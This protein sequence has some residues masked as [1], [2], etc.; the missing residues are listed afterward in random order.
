[1][2]ILFITPPNYAFKINGRYNFNVNFPL[3]MAYIAAIAEQGGHKV[4]VIDCVAEGW[5]V[6]SKLEDDRVR[7]GISP[8]ELEARVREYSPDIVGISVVTNLA[9]YV[10]KI[11]NAIRQNS[12]A[13]ILNT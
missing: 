9:K 12:K 8:E 3:G 11:V 5:S 10:P 7:I 2:R 4:G 6:H 1:M 13:I